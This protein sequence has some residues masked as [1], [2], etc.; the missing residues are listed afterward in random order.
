MI[1]LTDY[2][3]YKRKNSQSVNI[4]TERLYI[5]TYEKKKCTRLSFFSEFSILLIFKSIYGNIKFSNIQEYQRKD[6][7]TP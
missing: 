1:G 2:F 7:K 4:F 3:L 5:R 6:K